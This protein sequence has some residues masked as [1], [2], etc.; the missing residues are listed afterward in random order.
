ML[1]NQTRTKVSFWPLGLQ[2]QRE[3]SEK[4]VD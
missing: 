2:R 1:K 4:E 3:K